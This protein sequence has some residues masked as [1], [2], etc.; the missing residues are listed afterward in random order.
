MHTSRVSRAVVAAGLGGLLLLT[1]CSSDKK[2]G[3]ASTST[4]VAATATTVQPV[5]T[6]FSGEGSAQFCEFISTFTKGQQ[7]LST[8]ASP[9]AIRAAF[10]ESLAAVKQA[11]DVAPAEIKP[12]VVAVASSVQSIAD[13]MS[14]ANFDATKVD[15]SALTTLQSE[16]FMTSVTRMQAYLTNVCHAG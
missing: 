9:A 7:N 13:A 5:D 1:A 4:T 12:D 10:E 8:S 14:A 11:V 16:G 3:A 6:R 15:P 2:D